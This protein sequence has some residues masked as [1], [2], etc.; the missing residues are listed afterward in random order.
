ML[1]LCFAVVVGRLFLSIVKFH[2]NANNSYYMRSNNTNNRPTTNTMMMRSR[3]TVSKSGRKDS[4]Q[5]QQEFHRYVTNKQKDKQKQDKKTT[6]IMKSLLSLDD[7]AQ[8]PTTDTDTTTTTATVVVADNDNDK[9]STKS[10][11][12]STIKAKTTN[13]SS[14]SSSRAKDV[15]IA[16]NT[17]TTI[18]SSFMNDKNQKF[19]L[20]SSSSSSKAKS[21]SNTNTS[22]NNIDNN[23]DMTIIILSMDRFESLQRLVQSLLQAMYPPHDRIDIQI[24]FDRPQQYERFVGVSTTTTNTDNNTDT[25]TTIDTDSIE[26]R[27]VQVIMY[28]TWRE[29]I[30]RVEDYLKAR[31]TCG[32]VSVI[33]SELNLG[34]AQSWF[35]SWRPSSKLDRALILEDDVEVSPIYYLWLQH[36]H[37]NYGYGYHHSR[38]QQYITNNKTNTAANA[39]A[40]ATT[41]ET[42]TT[43][44]I[45]KQGYDQYGTKHSKPYPQI[46]DLAS[47][48]LPRQTLIPLKSQYHKSKQFKNGKS[49]IFPT[50]EPF[51]YSLLG[52]HGFS[53]LAHIWMEF[54]GK[55]I[56]TA[57]AHT[58]GYTVH[59]LDL[60]VYFVAFSS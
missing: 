35:T 1:L 46:P 29:K 16:R 3:R 49:G 11:T 2:T 32:Q 39:N 22:T 34:L 24:R 6:T 56:H 59:T 50:E 19:V 37:D 18:A 43:L 57:H 13:G 36:A 55:N 9:Y 41:I 38:K 44:R 17:T 60:C 30:Q 20:K 48:C 54:L 23:I 8:E 4:E 42:T 5:L 52:S 47:I 27:A 7:V 15:V 21:K 12:V 26:T 28:N 33:V 31:W 51:L 14:S 53:P 40:N 10:T 58:Q 45:N 25:T